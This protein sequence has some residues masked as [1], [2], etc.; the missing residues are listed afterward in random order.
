MKNEKNINIK[1]R[2]YRNQGQKWDQE[3]STTKLLHIVEITIHQTTHES[4][5]TNRLK[6]DQEYYVDMF[7]SLT[8][9]EE[10]PQKIANLDQVIPKL[11]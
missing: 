3:F 5:P 4:H 9:I 11:V 8:M 2:N 10:Q 7:S 1:S 6:I